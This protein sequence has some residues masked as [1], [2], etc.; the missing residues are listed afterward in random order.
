MNTKDAQ[1]AT[2][3]IPRIETVYPGIDE[4]IATG[5]QLE[6]R[7]HVSEQTIED[8]L[9]QPR[10]LCVHVPLQYDIDSIERQPAEDKHQ[11]NDNQH[12]YDAQSG[13]R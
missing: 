5:Q 10:P 6:Q 12:L 8:R 13:L 7:P 9:T 1:K 3:I 4:G 2:P 11:H